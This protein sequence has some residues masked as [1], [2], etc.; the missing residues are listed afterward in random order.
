MY[1][2]ATENFSATNKGTKIVFGTTPNG[3]NIG[4]PRMTIDH[5][6]NV[7]IGTTGPS[8]KLEVSGNVKI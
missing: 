2:Y 4:S 1:M 7:G 6:G 3:A 5:N 8:E